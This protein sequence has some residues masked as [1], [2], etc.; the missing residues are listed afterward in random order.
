MTLLNEIDIST[1]G[2]IENERVLV[3]NWSRFSIKFYVDGRI[4]RS[5]DSMQHLIAF[6]DQNPTKQERKKL[7]ILLQKRARGNLNFQRDN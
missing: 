2:L 6:R 1:T 4:Y 7:Q 3:K 5:K